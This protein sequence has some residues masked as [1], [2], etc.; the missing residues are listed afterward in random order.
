VE[1]TIEFGGDPQ[2]VTL[3]T[4]GIA[5]PQGLRRLSAELKS[6]PRYSPGL[7]ILADYSALDMSGLSDREIEQLAV[8][9]VERT[10]DSSPRALAIVASE[11]PTFAR[12]RE[13]VAFMGGLQANRRAFS[14]RAAAIA[15]LG[16]Q[17]KPT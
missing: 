4:S 13:G 6:D 17:V 15:W 10:W 5:D 2:D 12:V 7:L 9:S 8:E 1:Y 16:E 3:T 11:L 14:S